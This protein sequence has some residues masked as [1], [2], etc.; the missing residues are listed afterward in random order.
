M[1]WIIWLQIIVALI[2]VGLGAARLL[3][4]TNSLFETCGHIFSGFLLGLAL[5]SLTVT[6]FLLFLLLCLVELYKF[7][8]GTVSSS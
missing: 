1:N 2:S 6:Y 8:P 4:I 7:F 5:G 3:G